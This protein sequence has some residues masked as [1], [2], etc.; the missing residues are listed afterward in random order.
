MRKFWL[1]PVIIL[2][3]FLLARPR[4]AGQPAPDQ[5]DQAR[6]PEL[7]ATTMPSATSVT[8]AATTALIGAAE[9]TVVEQPAPS[10]TVQPTAP[11]V[12][13]PP[14]PPIITLT[15]LP[16]P[17]V[18]DDLAPPTALPTVE[19]PVLEPDIAPPTPAVIPSPQP[20]SFPSTQSANP[21][22][23]PE[24]LPPTRLIIPEIGLD[25][26]PVPVGVDEN[27][28]AIVPRHDAGWYTSSATPGQDSN[29]V[30]WG[31]VLRWKDSPH[32]PAPF[33]RVHELQPGAELMVVTADGEERRYRVAQQIQ[34]NPEDVQYVYPTDTER[35]TLVSCIGDKVIENGTLTREFRLITIAEPVE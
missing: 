23:Q 17:A 18:S 15:P 20:E 32:I 2:A 22:A 34:V 12:P 13:I 4:T 7:G 11:V 24:T 35:V 26:A 30:F 29:V 3:L 31:H 10:P 9:R 14:Q 16:T 21:S 33:A 6:R 19:P 1:L 27:R 28:V 5:V 25:L 8:T